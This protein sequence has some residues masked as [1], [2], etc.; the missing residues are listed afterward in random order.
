MTEISDFI[1]EPAR[2]ARSWLFD[3][4]APLWSSAGRTETGLLAEQ[5]MVR[6]GETTQFWRTF[7]Q[8]RHVF[9]FV[10]IGEL[11]WEGPW[12][13]L[14]AETV[15]TLLS[16]A[17]R[18]DG[19]FVHSLSADASV[20]DG[21]ADLYDQAFVLLAMATAG[22]AI[23]SGLF[24]EAERLLD[25]I[26]Q[27]WAHPSGGYREGEIA[28]PRLRR[29]NPHMH[30]LESL[31]ELF[32]RS[33]RRRF[34]DA[35]IRLADLAAA[36]FVDSGTGALLEYF[37][38]SLAPAEGQEGRLTEPGHCFEWAWL[39]E[40]LADL[41]WAKGYAISDRLT[42]FARSRGVDRHRGV[43]VNELCISGEV[44]NGGARL[45][46]QTERL[47]AAAVRA[48]RLGTRE[49]AVECQNAAASLHQYL[50][51]PLAGAWHDKLLADGSWVE[52][53]APGSS[54]Y[55]LTCAYAEL[56]RSARASPADT[57]DNP[58]QSHA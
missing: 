26:E 49:E 42:D 1:G 14:V 8:A 23:G 36:K 28:D 13:Q 39:F 35:A 18:P 34:G 15:E 17:R 10:T 31:I 24:D 37:G 56:I 9:S 41:G 57:G 48:A 16:K 38:E 25:L 3:R 20:A 2:A 51:V 52:E 54:F 55:H 5:L 47:K 22:S 50:D 4:A 53:P 6:P 27:A 21:R 11:G 12:R 29:Q 45:W 44:T 40:R 32:V 58:A 33:G 19:F 30:L 43:A 46:P 7:V